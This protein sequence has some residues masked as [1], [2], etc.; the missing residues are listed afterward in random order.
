MNVKHG[1][2]LF[3]NVI[4][5]NYVKRLH[6]LETNELVDEDKMEIKKLAK[7]PNIG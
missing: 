7:L 1:F 6:E 5:A 3:S 4:E 2:P